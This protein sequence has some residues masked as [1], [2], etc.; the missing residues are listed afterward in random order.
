MLLDP[1]LIQASIARAKAARLDPKDLSRRIGEGSRARFT[2]PDQRQSRYVQILAE[3][4]DPGYARRALE[5][6]I[7][8]NDLVAINYLTRGIVAARSV[9]RLRLRSSSGD[10]IGF[11]TGFLV[12]PGVLLTNH[13]VLRNATEAANAIAE[14]DYEADAQGKAKV[15]VCFSVLGDPAPVVQEK[16]DFAL[17]GVAAQ[18]LE[19]G[20]A[21]RE[22]GFLPLNPVPG[23]AFIGEYLTIIQHPGG[24]RKQ[25]CVRENKLLK[26]DENDDTLWYETD[27]VGGSS[28]A[29]V[30]NTAWQVVALHHSGVPETD[31]QNRWLTVDGGLWDPSMDESQVAWKANE[32]IRVSSIMRH[33]KET[34]LGHP[35]TDA[36]FELLAAPEGMGE[37]E[38]PAPAASAPSALPRSEV[39]DG[40]LRVTIP[41]HVSV[42]VGDAPLSKASPPAPSAPTP[43]A[44]PAPAPSP[45]AD[46]FEAVEVDQTNYAARTGYQP[47][48]LGERIP[49]PQVT[50][51]RGL[52]VLT[53]ATG[54][55]TTSEIKY[56]TYSVVMCR[57]RRLAFLSAAN[58]NAR[59][60][61]QSGSREGDKWYF[62][63]RLEDEE[64]LGPEFYG[65]QK[66][67]EVDRTKNPFDRGHLTRRLDAQWGRSAPLQKRNG[68]DSFHWTN[69]APQHFRF[70]QGAKR[71]LGL[72]DYV[73]AGFA[74]ETGLATLFNGP[75]FDAPVSRLGEDGEIE[76]DLRGKRHPDPTFGDVQIPKLFF[77]IV[78]C[79]GKRGKLSSAAFL[80]SQEDFLVD[81][82]RLRGMPRLEAL[83]EPEARLYQV[84]IA[85]VERLTAITFGK[86]G[87][88]EVEL[89]EAARVGRP[90]RVRAL[91]DLVF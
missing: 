50:G 1:K 23:K 12:A 6:I 89:A 19:G 58:V 55:R 61:P 4:G 16:L 20:R 84:R 85:D 67:F 41:V 24:E 29:P 66:T 18:S 42:R 56:W 49:L 54:R 46:T 43:S 74:S 30:F 8:G 5:R 14:F 21:L 34:A 48:F 36:V 2:T 59:E 52:S 37:A 65:A 77:K 10:T 39:R 69:C 3:S 35:L 9:C 88:W 38:M 40:E 75:V 17:V 87:N 47:A 71:W 91:E 53:F 60:R 22:F 51:R 70:N 32:G 13:H 83:S 82:T 31:G 63:S 81:T 79:R 64:Q 90:R 33:L 78:V 76:L 80:M 73:I 86:V 72:E 15:A 27:T 44:R 11:G 57:Q 25:I 7:R 62:D 45:T 28:G 26:Y 68:D